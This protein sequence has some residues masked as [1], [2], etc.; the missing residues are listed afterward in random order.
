MCSRVKYTRTMVLW[1]QAG[2]ANF[3]KALELRCHLIK[4]MLLIFLLVL[5]RAIHPM[6]GLYTKFQYA[7]KA[8]NSRLILRRSLN[9]ILFE[10]EEVQVSEAGSSVATIQ[11]DDNRAQHILKVVTLV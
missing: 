5:S 6:H 4:R 8:G 3:T 10:R 7:A 1:S 9:R 2:S 11:K